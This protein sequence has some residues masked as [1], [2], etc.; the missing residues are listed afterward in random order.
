[1]ADGCR[2][3]VFILVVLLL[4]PSAIM[5]YRPVII[6]HGLF[7]GPKE[8]TPFVNFIKESHP[9][10]SVTAPSLYEYAASVKPMWVQVEGFKKVIQPIM[11]SAEDGVHLI[12]YS[13]GGL[14]C[15]GVL[16]TLPQHNAHSVIFLSSPLAGQYGVTRAIS[17][18]FPKLPKSSLHNVCYTELGQKTSFC[19]Y[20][21]DP[22]HREKY[23]NSSVF[24]A[25]LNGEVE[26]VNSTEWRNNFLRIKT[27]VLIGGPNDGVILPWQSSMFGSYDRN[28]KVIDMEN[29]DFYVRDT[30]GLKTLKSQGVLWKC[31]IP[32]VKH[33]SWPSDPRVFQNCVEKWLT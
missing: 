16:A 32:R 22:H 5:A 3:C 9:G 21:N 33:N 7:G 30:F 17:G 12:C 27:M 1:M 6:I 26:H 19:S 23:L 24:L 20:W 13:Q 8:L 25:P 18:V 4:L 10:T 14:I 31:I 28:G 15:R 11:E 2:P 29:Q